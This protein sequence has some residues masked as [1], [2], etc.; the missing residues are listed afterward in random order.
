M[1]V[2]PIVQIIVEF[3][4]PIHLLFADL[5]AGK[6]LLEIQI[7]VSRRPQ[8]IDYILFQHE[9]VQIIIEILEHISLGCDVWHSDTAIAIADCDWND[10]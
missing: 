9:I 1:F 2:R 6:L 8:S 4:L 3:H 7:D 10:R 5:P